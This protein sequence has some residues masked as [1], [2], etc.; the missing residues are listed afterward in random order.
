VRKWIDD[1]IA[2]QLDQIV[3]CKRK[4][5][6]EWSFHHGKKVALILILNYFIMGIDVKRS[7]PLWAMG[8]IYSSGSS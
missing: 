3:N 5:V 6:E 7:P 1:N 8:R 4:V 2:E